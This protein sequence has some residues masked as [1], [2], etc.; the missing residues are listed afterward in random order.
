MEEARVRNVEG[1]ER[2]AAC[3]AEA[4]KTARN[5]LVVGHIDADGITAAS[6]AHIALKRAGVRP[7]VVF[8]KKLGVEEIKRFNADQHELIWFVDMG[9]GALSKLVARKMV[10]T[11]HHRPDLPE[12][13]GQADLS[14]FLV[15]HV[16]P[17]LFGLDGSTEM[18]GSGATYCVAKAMDKRNKDLAPLAVI[19][20]VGD[21]QDASESRLIGYNHLI[22]EDAVSTGI[23][24]A[25]MDV[26]LF[27]R[28]TRPIHT[29][30]QFSSDPSVL[31]ILRS[32]RTE[33][34]DPGS[35]DAEDRTICI[36][37]LKE[38]D[39]RVKE[40]DDFRCWSN[41]APDE[42][43]RIVSALCNRMLDLGRG[44]L[45]RRFIGEVYTLS[46]NLPGTPPGW[47]SIDTDRIRED[48]YEWRPNV[49]ALFD[50]KEFATLL[51][52]CGRHDRSE[53]GMAVCM[54]DRGMNLRVAL[55]EQDNHRESL[56]QAIRLVKEN[57][58]FAIR[59]DPEL[60]N[61]RYFHAHDLIEDTIVG[62]VAGMLLG[63]DDVPSDR[64]II[65]FAE[66]NDGTGSIKISTRGTREL[67]R[68]GLDLSIA[69]KEASESCGGTGGG[70]NIA[71]GATVPEGKEGNFLSA[72]D[73]IIGRQLRR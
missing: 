58:D 36:D 18:S 41:L 38:L 50:A 35:R 72:I 65:A 48:G 57:P 37:F 3:A 6:I 69:I 54:G 42:K 68:C 61:I 64:P 10:I 62:I 25:G 40:G 1:L 46:P 52:A 9:S 53:V 20:A 49:R 23:L 59:T 19:G 28:E 13:R 31:P 66:S 7:D 15:H 14:R 71:A 47:S 2:A 60:K 21:F 16:N 29:L 12:N 11:D 56:K 22:V 63:S 5:A 55:S 45:I 26:R 17:H 27:G 70:H 24:K 34:L 44:Q 30:I 8:V 4:L 39:I 67:V 43:K 51:N 33:P 73:Q 32:T